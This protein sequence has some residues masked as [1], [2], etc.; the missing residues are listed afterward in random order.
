MKKLW[1]DFSLADCLLKAGWLKTGSSC[2]TFFCQLAAV[3]GML[4][5]VPTY[6]SVLLFVFFLFFCALFLSVW[7]TIYHSLSAILS[8]F[9]VS[10][11]TSYT[12]LCL[13]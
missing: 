10:R 4:Y 7:D 12:I 8:S 1:L 11:G 3:T 13:K 2:H 9:I 6:Q 5:H